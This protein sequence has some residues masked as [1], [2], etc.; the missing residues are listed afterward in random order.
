MMFH[1]DGDRVLV[2]ASNAGDQAHPA[3]YLN[4][5]AN[6]RVTVEIGDA[7]YEAIATPTS[8]DERERLWTVIKDNYPFFADHEVKAG[9]EIPIVALEKV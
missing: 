8:G 5:V 1:R 9:R 4:L 6:P 3:W 2:M 7:K